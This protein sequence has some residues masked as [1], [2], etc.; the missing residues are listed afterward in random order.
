MRCPVE[1][2]RRREEV[3]AAQYRTGKVKFFTH[4]RGFGFIEPDSGGQDVYMTV[5]SFPSLT[6]SNRGT[7]E[8]ARLRFQTRQTKMGLSAFDATV[9]DSAP[10]TETVAQRVFRV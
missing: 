1:E 9:V 2:D 7:V 10:K 5:G 8:G 3:M 4:A 6:E